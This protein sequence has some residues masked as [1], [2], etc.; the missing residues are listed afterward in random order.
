MCLFVSG[1]RFVEPSAGL[2]SQN[3]S[4]ILR[5][6]AMT[7]I[8]IVFLRRLGSSL[9]MW[10]IA[11]YIILSG[12]EIG[13]MFLIGSLGL[14]GLWEYYR[15]LDADKLPNFKIIGL[16]CGAS[17]TAGNFY[18]FRTVGPV[19]SYDFEIATLLLFLLVVFSRQMF[20]KTRDISP[21]ETMA[22]TV[23][24]L[25]YV[26]WLFSF[27]TKIVYLIPRD[28][29]GNLTGHFYVLW[30]VLV[31]K[32]SDMGAYVTGSLF[33][34]HLLVPHISPKKTWEGLFGALVFSTAGACGLLALIPQKLSLL[35]QS[36]AVVLGVVLGFAAIVGDLAESV[37]KRSAGV[38]DSG[39]FLPGIGG[40]LD[41]IDSILFTAPLLFFYL[42][43]FAN[44]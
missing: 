33:G 37:I 13:F 36:D 40:A 25:L 5:A 11:L 4:P 22:Y 3:S 12:Y 42:R 6:H 2:P 44:V 24:G 7:P 19:Q 1:L 35:Q 23:F 28:V 29:D 32:F 43:F 17:L 14:I 31:T 20:Q 38:K 15:M 8:Q 34:K 21:L 9:A 16:I 27:V 39:N 18:Y 30:L 41:L 26:P 10:S